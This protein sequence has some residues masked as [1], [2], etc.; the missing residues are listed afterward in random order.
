ML[1]TSLKNARILIV[2]DQ[3]SNIALLEGVLGRNGYADRRS[4]TD[5]RLVVGLLDDYHPDLVLLDLLMPH[6]DGFA[7]MERVRARV[8]AEDYLP[9]LV[10]TADITPEAKLRALAAGAN[11]FLTKPFDVG[12]VTLRIRN[13][14]ETRQLHLQLKDQNQVLE[15]KVQVRTAE[16][17]QRMDDLALINALNTSMNRGDGIQEI[18]VTLSDELH[19]IFGC[20][21]TITAFPDTDRKTLR[22]QHLE[23][24]S[25]LADQIEKLA[26]A[27]ILSLPIRIP[28]TG[29]GHFAE[30]LR[31]GA[32]LA[33]NDE[34]AIIAAMAEFTEDKLLRH[35]ASPV[36]KLLGIGS[37]LLIPLNSGKEVHGLL[38]MVRKETTTE[39]ELS[40][41][42]NIA[43]HLAAAIGR[44]LA[45]ERI[46]KSLREKEMLIRELYHRTKNTMQV[47]SGMMAFQA[48][49]LGSGKDLLLL[50]GNTNERIQAI[51][52]AHEML[53]QS[54]DL[55][56]IS[57][58]DYIGVLS[59]RIFKG[60]GPQDNRIAIRQ[61]IDDEYLLID[62]AIPLGMV[63]NE[64]ITN[65]LQHAFPGDR[66]GTIS[67]ALSKEGPLCRLLY[68]DD[69]VG[70]PAGFDFRSSG[71]LGL[72]LVRELGEQQLRGTVAMASCRG[73]QV[74]I[75]F[76]ADLYKAR[77]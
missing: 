46:K 55:S 56:Q 51:S 35:L 45:D 69:G 48:E 3:E 15:E 70:V 30:A 31:T 32:A 27:G 65:S 66:K 57:M 73:I 74:S 13:L 12:E 62:T 2:D 72:R 75:E 20:I 63:L 64:L 61:V 7:V 43:A 29:D 10:L 26:G 71:T 68:S 37:M 16:L 77:V 49:E 44:K 5:P 4:T 47:I 59:S 21:G 67:I 50:V 52:L 18:I 76:S 38:E 19:R 34:D 9:I 23:F 36:R 41:V 60:Y 25:P 24:D 39:P 33:I 1:D 40:R 28:M 17:R 8:P 11:D 54:Q 6:L 53:L 58:A 42:R 14:L 22:I